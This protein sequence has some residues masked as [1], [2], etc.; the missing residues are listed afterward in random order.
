MRV[1]LS[2]IQGIVGNFRGPFG[3]GNAQSF[4]ASDS[5]FD[6]MYKGMDVRPSAYLQGAPD[7]AAVY[8]SV[9]LAHEIDNVL[10][11]ILYWGGG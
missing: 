4:R 3:I 9:V 5:T 2:V 6:E 1:D 8:V 7:D 10:A 11:Q